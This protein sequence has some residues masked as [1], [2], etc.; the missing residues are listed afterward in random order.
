MSNY[1]M[2]LDVR[3]WQVAPDGSLPREARAMMGSDEYPEWR[4]G[5]YYGW[6]I[7]PHSDPETLEHALHEYREWAWYDDGTSG[8]CTASPSDWVIAHEFG[9]SAMSDEQF[10]EC[11]TE[12][13]DA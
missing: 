10:R 6:Q 2:R 3:A 9:V 7:V 11:C 8:L 5:R 12:V 4:E 13:A 1:T